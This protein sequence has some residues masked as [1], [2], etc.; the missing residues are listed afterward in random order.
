MATLT[1]LGHSAF[2]IESDRGKRV[3]VD[4]FL[5]G[6][7]KAPQDALQPERVDIIAVTHGHSD[8]VGDTVQLSKSFPDVQIVAQVELKG[9]LG[10]QGA[11]VG[12]LPGINK[13]G[14]QEIDGI[15]FS[16]VNAFHSSSSNDGDY[17]GEA[18]GIV[19]RLE[20][21]KTIYFAGD[22]CVFGDMA[23]IAR[24][25]EPDVAVLPIGDWF[26][27][28]PREAAVALELLGNPRCVPCHFGT[29]PLLT[30]TPDE[31]AQL[32]PNAKVERLEP[33]DSID[34]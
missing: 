27:M 14:S 1:W 11:N 13:G 17:L 26:T 8:H 21:G 5:N 4:P 10:V 16:L 2:R 28:S 34:V 9:W 24:I 23:L 20:D 15:R 25:H 18:C 7:P 31:L 30:G 3:Y 6:N 32:A 19:V 22:T 12:E 33:G 29:F